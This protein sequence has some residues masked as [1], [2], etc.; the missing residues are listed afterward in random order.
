MDERELQRQFDI[1]KYCQSQIARCDLSGLMSYCEGCEFRRPEK[2]VNGNYCVTDHVS[3]ETNCYCAKN[4]I[5]EEEKKNAK[6]VK[7]KA[8]TTRGKS[9]RKS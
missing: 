3:R 9:K 4:F 6:E 7:P 2:T 8:K 5:R 1:K